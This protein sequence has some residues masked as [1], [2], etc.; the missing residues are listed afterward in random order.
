MIDYDKVRE[1]IETA[2]REYYDKERCRV[3]VARPP[4]GG[5]AELVARASSPEARVLDIGCGNG[6]TLLKAAASFREGVG[7]DNDEKHL[8][9]AEALKAESGVRNVTFVHGWAHKMPFETASFDVV[10]SE[11]GPLAGYDVNVRNAVRV[12]RS[13]GTIF[14][15]TP[16]PRNYHEVGY[17]FDPHQPPI[18]ALPLTARIEDQ[19]A[20]F[21]RNG[22]AVTLAQSHLETL[23]FPDVYEWLRHHLSQWDYFDSWRLEWPLSDRRK[24]GIECFLA[25]AADDAGRIRITSHRLWI[26]GVKR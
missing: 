16:G 21:E 22:V 24:L 4:I 23:V 25:M 2:G 10:F 15:E 9:Q 11:R 26:G 3:E 19:L 1:V 8:A 12:L 7:L 18:S 5:F 17:I 6:R 14:Y 20:V 13:G